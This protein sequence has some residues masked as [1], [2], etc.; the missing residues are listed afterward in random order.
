MTSKSRRYYATR[1]FERTRYQS[2]RRRRVGLSEQACIATAITGFCRQ[3]GS[4]QCP[5]RCTQDHVQCREAW[6]ATSADQTLLQGGYQ[7]PASHDE[8]R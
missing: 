2:L 3:D 5:A 7:V 1:D 8:A 6:Q 4:Y